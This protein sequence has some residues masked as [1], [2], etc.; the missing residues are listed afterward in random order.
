[1]DGGVEVQSLAA[2]N[3]SMHTPTITFLVLLFS[4]AGIGRAAEVLDI[5]DQNQIFLDGRFLQEAEGVKLKVCPP[6]KTDE[7]CWRGDTG[8][9]SQIMEPDGVFRGV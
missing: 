3:F 5:G 6:K 4:L 8:G 2:D 9:Y 1:M 7:Q